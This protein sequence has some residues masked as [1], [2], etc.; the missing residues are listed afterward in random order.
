MIEVKPI[1]VAIGIN[2]TKLLDAKITLLSALAWLYRPI[3]EG[4]DVV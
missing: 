2:E 1:K 4:F 3:S